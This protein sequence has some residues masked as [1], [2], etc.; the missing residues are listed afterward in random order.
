[1]KTGDKIILGVVVML[2]FFGGWVC[3]RNS[4]IESG[5]KQKNTVEQKKESDTESMKT[6]AYIVSQDF[7]KARLK[8]P[9]TAD[10]PFVQ[11]KDGYDP[12]S[13]IYT[14][15]SHVDSQNSFGAIVRMEYAIQM[16]FNGGEA[17]D[18]NNW[19]V[20]KIGMQ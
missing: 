10:F 17:D 9:S 13:K 12:A 15:V 19:A 1:M 6:S 7:V 5:L 2:I 8:S 20:V 18:P 3:S 4:T 11:E 16:K 14:I